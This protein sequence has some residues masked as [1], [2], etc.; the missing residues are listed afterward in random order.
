MPVEPL[1]RYLAG[2]TFAE[3]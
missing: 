2:R 3:N 1:L